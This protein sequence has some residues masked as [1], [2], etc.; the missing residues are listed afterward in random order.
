MLRSVALA[1]ALVGIGA[2]TFAPQGSAL[3]AAH[4][5]PGDGVLIPGSLSGIHE[6]PYSTRLVAKKKPRK[7]KKGKEDE[8]PTDTPPL[9]S[10]DEA[11]PPASPVGVLPPP[12]KLDTTRRT[13]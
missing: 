8:V 2:W 3:A 6:A 1:A 13:V 11:P 10:I 12:P 5:G 4:G 9:E 7:K